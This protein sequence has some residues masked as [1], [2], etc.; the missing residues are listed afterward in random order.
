MRY[1]PEYLTA[2][3]AKGA[4]RQTEIQER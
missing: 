2:E 1:D 3:V 4:E